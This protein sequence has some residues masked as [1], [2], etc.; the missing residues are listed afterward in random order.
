[1]RDVVSTGQGPHIG[2]MENTTLGSNIYDD[3]RFSGALLV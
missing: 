3:G 1:M 2:D